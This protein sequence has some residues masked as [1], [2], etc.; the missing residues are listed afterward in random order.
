MN[1][2]MEMDKSLAARSGESLAFQVLVFH[3]KPSEAAAVERALR[4]FGGPRRRRGA[5]LA[6]AV[7]A[8]VRPIRIRG[9]DEK[10]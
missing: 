6:S 5:A 4:R 2:G 10:F 3:V 8:A 1:K 7:R 9:E